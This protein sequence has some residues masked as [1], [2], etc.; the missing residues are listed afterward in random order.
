M[1]KKFDMAV[2]GATGAVGQTMLAIMAER[3]LTI[4]KIY[5][6][7]SEQSVGKTISFAG[8]KLIVASLANFDFRQAQIALFSAGSQISKYY[9][10]IAQ[11]PV[12]SL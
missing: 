10:P 6:L 1:N 9:A 4:D 8:Q 3:R 2:I 7:A 11:R 12:V 5:V